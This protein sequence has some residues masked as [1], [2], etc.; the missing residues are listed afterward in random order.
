MEFMTNNYR[1]SDIDRLSRA[2]AMRHN[3]T[4]LA[5]SRVRDA[6]ARVH[7]ILQEDEKIAR[8]IQLAQTKSADV[9]LLRKRRKALIQNLEHAKAKLVEMNAH[10][11]EAQREQKLSERVQARSLLEWERREA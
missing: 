5:E 2:S 11:V 3:L 4:I 6:E 9:E 8:E 10:W 1:V 7:V